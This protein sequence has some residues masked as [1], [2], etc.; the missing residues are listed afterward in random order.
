MTICIY[1]GV[2]FKFNGSFKKATDKQVT[3]ARNR[4]AILALLERSRI[5]RLPVDIMCNLF[6]ACVRYQ[7]SCMVQKFGDL[8]ISNISSMGIHTLM[9]VVWRHRH[10]KYVH[11][12]SQENDQLLAKNNSVQRSFPLF[13]A[14]F[15]QTYAQ[16]HQNCN[17]KWCEK[18]KN[19]L[20]HTG[21]PD[22]CYAQ[23]VD[24]EYSSSRQILHSTL[25]IF[26]CRNGMKIC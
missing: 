20:N 11:S 16:K 15:Y 2:A 9:Y 17:F 18:N 7:S 24:L 6:D 13:Y 19:I 5:L 21:F 4:K 26:S 3:K 25:I 10:H 14:N 12:G 22:A 23:N 1:F 8:E